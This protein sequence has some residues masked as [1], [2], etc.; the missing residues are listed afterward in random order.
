MKNT[1]YIFCGQD[2][3]DI[4]SELKA[5]N[6]VLRRELQASLFA[7]ENAK[8]RENEF[9]QHSDKMA[10]SLQREQHVVKGL[11]RQ[12]EQDQ[13]DRYGTIFPAVYITQTKISFFPRP[14]LVTA[15]ED[16]RNQASRCQNLVRL[17]KKL[18]FYVAC[19]PMVGAGGGTR[20]EMHC[21]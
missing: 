7:S 2:L 9:E 19:I 3:R 16:S 10:A 8:K 4:A 1:L 11:L 15:L 13:K 14:A 5:A 12:I 6:E 18:M 17:L 21:S 20:K